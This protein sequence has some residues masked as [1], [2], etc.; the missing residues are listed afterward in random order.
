MTKSRLRKVYEKEIKKIVASLKP[1][2][3]ERIIL[4]GSGAR[5]NFGEDSD[6]DLFLIKKSKKRRIDRAREVR[7]FIRNTTLPVDFLVY[8]PQEVKRALAMGSFF[9]EDILK[10][11]KIVYEAQK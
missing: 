7:D 5:G 9:I 11:G 1:Y 10:E 3:P 4:F 8:T 2:K 6:I